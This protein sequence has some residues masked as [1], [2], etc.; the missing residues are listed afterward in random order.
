MIWYRKAK[1]VLG[2]FNRVKHILV[3]KTIFYLFIIVKVDNGKRVAL[4][5]YTALIGFNVLYIFR[6]KGRA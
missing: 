5:Y 2:A 6:D 3:F 1:C 4:L